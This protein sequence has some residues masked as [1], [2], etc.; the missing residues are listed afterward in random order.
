MQRA[1]LAVSTWFRLPEYMERL[2]ILSRGSAFR[3]ASGGVVASA[4]VLAPWRFPNYFPEEWVKSVGPEHTRYFLERRSAAGVV[5]ACT[6]ASSPVCH[7]DRD[8]AVLTPVDATAL[9]VLGAPA[10]DLALGALEDGAALP[11][12]GEDVWNCYEVSW[13][14]HRGRP[15]RG[16]VELRIPCES[17][18]VVESK[19]LKLYLN[20]LNF[21]RFAASLMLYLFLIW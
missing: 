15:R 11:F 16:A 21:K 8:A 5:E 13:L 10:L 14:D 7:A 9:D 12:Q 18:N 1:S 19:S 4:H 6:E 2:E 3:L 20:S 17:P